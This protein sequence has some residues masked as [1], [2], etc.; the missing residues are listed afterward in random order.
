M[1]DC[2]TTIVD[3]EVSTSDAPK[4]GATIREWL[5]A[6]GVI[7][8]DPSDCVLGGDGYRPGSVLGLAI[9]PGDVDRYALRR[10]LTNGLEIITERAL[11][12]GWMEALICTRCNQTIDYSEFEPVISTAIQNWFSSGVGDRVDCPRCGMGVPLTEWRFDPPV[13]FGNLGFKFWNWPPLKTSFI[14]EVARRLGH[15]VVVVVGKL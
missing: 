4:L 7:Q 14:A 12:I 2:H 9:E 1:G 5:I 3:R 10:L 6:E 8:A 13:G 11:F 15:R